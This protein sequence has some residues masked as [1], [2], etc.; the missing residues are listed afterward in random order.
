MHAT[1]PPHIPNYKK[2]IFNDHSVLFTPND[3]TQQI[4]SNAIDTLV[5]KSNMM[6]NRICICGIFSQRQNHY[7]NYN[8]IRV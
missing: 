2:Q 1:V 7:T 3:I 6:Q 4:C 8:R 5:P